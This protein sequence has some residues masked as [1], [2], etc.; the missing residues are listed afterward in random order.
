MNFFIHPKINEQNFPQ[1]L[2]DR[3]PAGFQLLLFHQPKMDKNSRTHL[4][5]RPPPSVERSS[6]QGSLSPRFYATRT[7]KWLHDEAEG[8][9]KFSQSFSSPRYIHVWRCFEPNFSNDTMRIAR[10]TLQDWEVCA[11]LK[12]WTATTT[13]TTTTDEESCA[14]FFLWR[15]RVFMYSAI[16]CFLLHFVALVKAQVWFP[17]V[18][19]WHPIVILHSSLF[20]CLSKILQFSNGEKP[21]QENTL[22]RL[23][24]SPFVSSTSVLPRD[25]LSL[26]LY[27]GRNFKPCYIQL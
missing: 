13:T 5:T 12:W 20:T 6:H 9:R 14:W 8:G 3:S 10:R 11:K 16:Y 23:S 22:R 27:V 7:E 25:M 19:L 18:W 2:K 26:C 4:N 17:S 24:L 1:I 15:T 21:S